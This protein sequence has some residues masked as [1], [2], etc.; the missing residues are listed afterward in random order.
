MQMLTINKG[1]LDNYIFTYFE[2]KQKPQTLFHLTIL[3]RVKYVFGPHKI[4]IF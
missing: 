4:V 2:H 1:I 3:L